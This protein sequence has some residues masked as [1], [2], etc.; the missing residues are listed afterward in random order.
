MSA[1]FQVEYR[2]KDKNSRV[3][4]FRKDLPTGQNAD[5]EEKERYSNEKGAHRRTGESHQQGF[6]LRWI[7]PFFL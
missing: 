1:I 3:T 7:D 6:C 5:Q 2:D 4:S